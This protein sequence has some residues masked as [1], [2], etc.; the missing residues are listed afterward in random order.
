MEMVQISI[1]F[2][3]A[4]ANNITR[5]CFFINLFVVIVANFLWLIFS[6]FR[7]TGGFAVALLFFFL[8]LNPHQGRTLRQHAQEFDFIGL[9]LMVAGVICLLIGFN[10]GE[11]SC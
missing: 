9:F 7:P 11:T 5:R 3:I 6:P 10:S 4:L 8:N 1:L 2:Y